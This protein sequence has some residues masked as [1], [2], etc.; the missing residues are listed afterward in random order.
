MAI[1]ELNKLAIENILTVVERLQNRVAK[2]ELEK[3][4]LQGKVNDLEEIHKVGHQ[5][6]KGDW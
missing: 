3:N 5:H 6:F 1:I 2:L 4:V